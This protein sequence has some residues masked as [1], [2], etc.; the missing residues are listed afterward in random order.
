MGLHSREIRLLKYDLLCSLFVSVVNNLV[1]WCDKERASRGS[2]ITEGIWRVCKNYSAEE[3]ESISRWDT[4]DG[5]KFYD[6]QG[7]VLPNCYCFSSTILICYV[8]FFF[9]AYVP[10]LSHDRGFHFDKHIVR[11]YGTIDMRGKRKLALNG[12]G[13][14]Y[15]QENCMLIFLLFASYFN[16][17]WIYLILLC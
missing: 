9:F 7:Y 10:V 5:I 3:G 8:S 6:M 17:L 16:V 15:E 1:H 14:L 4:G 12:N 2:S 13:I 11:P